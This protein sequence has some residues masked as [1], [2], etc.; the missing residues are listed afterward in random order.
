[1][2][3][4]IPMQDPRLT[5][6][7]APAFHIGHVRRTAWQGIPFSCLPAVPMHSGAPCTTSHSPRPARGAI[8]LHRHILEQVHPGAAVLHR[9]IL[10]QSLHRQSH[11]VTSRSRAGVGH[12]AI[13]TSRQRRH[14]VG[15]ALA[16]TQ[17]GT[18]W[19]LRVGLKAGPGAAARLEAG[20]CKEGFTRLFQMCVVLSHQA[21]TDGSFFFAVSCPKR[22]CRN[23]YGIFG[24]FWILLPVLTCTVQPVGHFHQHM[25]T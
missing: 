2:L 1:M 15:I 4:C 12:P 24:L 7:G 17:G 11:D 18:A 6:P 16:S 25:Q 3:P 9:H 23:P 22:V 5:C 10:R 13:V 19:H 8:G 20:N 21:C 14:G